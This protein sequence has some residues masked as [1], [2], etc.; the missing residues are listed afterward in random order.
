MS[1]DKLGRAGTGGLRSYFGSSHSGLNTVLIISH[2]ESLSLFVFG[3]RNVLCSWDAG[4]G[5]QHQMV[6]FNSFV[7][8][9]HQRRH[10]RV[11]RIPQGR[12]L[13]CP[14]INPD[15]AREMAQST[16]TRLEKALTA[17]GDVQGPALEV[18]KSELTKAKSA[19]QQPPLDV[20]TDQCRTC[21]TRAEKRIKEL[22][23]QRE[24]E[25][26]LRTEAQDRLAR[27]VNAQSRA[28]ATTTSATLVQCHGHHVGNRSRDPAARRE[29]PH[30]EPGRDP[31]SG[32]RRSGRGS[33]EA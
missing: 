30:W 22:D 20:E 33:L 8:R 7:D 32:H 12:W 10:G 25:N 17:M 28:P 26:A 9:A 18:L 2:C 14:R 19:S 11:Q 16:V 5:V 24:E 31:T 23:A 1:V 13:Q 27:L 15:K 21:I 3:C 4:V 6:G 29:D